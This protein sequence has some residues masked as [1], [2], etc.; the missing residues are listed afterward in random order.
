LWADVY[1]YS[2][3]LT[4]QEIEAALFFPCSDINATIENL[5]K[6]YGP[7]A[8]IAVIPEG[9]QTIPVSL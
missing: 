5:Q 1:V 4:A 8:S 2:H 3:G 9:P 6:K 7:Q